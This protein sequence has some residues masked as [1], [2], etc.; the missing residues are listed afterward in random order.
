VKDAV[1]A[2]VIGVLPGTAWID[3]LKFL[4]VVLADH[5]S[6]HLH[7]ARRSQIL[8]PEKSQLAGKGIEGAR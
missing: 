6:E 3:V 5:I 7:L 1:E 8:W 2:F 4:I